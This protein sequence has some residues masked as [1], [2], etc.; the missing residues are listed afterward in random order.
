M[1]PT[2]RHPR[3]GL[4]VQRGNLQHRRSAVYPESCQQRQEKALLLLVAGIHR[5]VRGRRQPRSPTRRRR[6]NATATSRS[7]LATATAPGCRNRFWIPPTIT[8]QFA[9]NMI[10]ASRINPLGQA[11]MNFFPLPN[12]SPTISTQL[13]VDNFTEQGSATHPRRNDVARVDLYV[14]SKISAYVRW[15]HDQ[16]RHDGSVSGRQ[17]R[18]ERSGRPHLNRRSACLRWLHLS[19]ESGP[20]LLRHGDLH[21]HAD[22]DQRSH[23]F[24][25]LEYLVLLHDSTTMPANQPQPDPRSAHAVPGTDHGAERRSGH[26]QRLRKHPADVQLLGHAAGSNRLFAYR[27]ER[28]PEPMR[29]SIRFT[30]IRTTSARSRATTH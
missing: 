1:A 7:R 9:D 30:L 17:L 6:W 5:P 23:G 28:T 29:T 22:A 2:S 27:T 20:R 21:D 19:P 13:Y 11:L 25:R 26:R 14:T 10:P 24:R 16:R 15:I 18:S 3:A 12:Y 4:P 8:S